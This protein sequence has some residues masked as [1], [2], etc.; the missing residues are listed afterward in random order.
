MRRSP[1]LTLTKEGRSR[2][3]ESASSQGAAKS[4]TYIDQDEHA[5]LSAKSRD[6]RTSAHTLEARA[7]Y[8]FKT[9]AVYTG[10]WSGDARHGF[11]TQ[12][13]PNGTVY[14]GEWRHNNADG[15]GRLAHSKGD[16][17]VGE[18]AGS[19]CHGLGV[20]HRIDGSDIN[21]YRGEWRDDVRH[22]VAVETEKDGT[23]FEGTF[24]DG[25]KED[26]G[27]FRWPDGS[28][29]Y[30]T[31]ER[32]SING[33]GKYVGCDGRTFQGGWSHCML[34]GPG[35]YKWPD[36]RSYRGQYE[37]D[38]KVGFGIILWPD[39]Q[40]YE[41]E[42]LEGKQHGRG[43]A[44]DLALDQGNQEGDGGRPGLVRRSE[45]GWVMGQPANRAI[46]ASIDDDTAKLKKSRSQCRADRLKQPRGT[47]K[48]K[49]SDSDSDL[50]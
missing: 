13:W 34:H 38:K 45:G 14:E 11:G 6:A 5:E 18:M 29:Y 10:Q 30:G 25:T 2:S 31:W 33:L 35:E 42:W 15:R 36:G 16:V 9:G 3:A 49:L 28:E 4:L 41:G 27:C 50:S 24:D 8:V 44:L 21:I 12:C 40:S 22:G 48:K 1:S 7:P 17:Y 43:V 23:C 39:G 46:R 37:L 47:K 32:N 20:C 26:Y 19:C